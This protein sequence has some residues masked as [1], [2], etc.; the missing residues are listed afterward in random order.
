MNQQKNFILEWSQKQLGTAKL[1]ESS[2]GALIKGILSR[3]L[4]AIAMSALPL[5]PSARVAFQRAR[6]VKIGK[7]VFIGLG[8]WLDSV[9]PELITIEDAVSLAGRVTIFTHSDPTEPIR[10]LLKNDLK[11]VF[12]PVIIKNGAWIAVNATILP[13]VTIGKNSIVAAGSVVTK[14]IPDNVIAGG[15][16]AKIIRSLINHC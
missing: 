4:S 10:E 9:S 3:F 7:D 14:D 13:G 11:E 16:P 8:C 6:G 1:E 12:M 2:I 15:V 5:P